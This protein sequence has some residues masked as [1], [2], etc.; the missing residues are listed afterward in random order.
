MQLLALI[1]TL[2][3]IAAKHG[4]LP[5][6]LHVLYNDGNDQ[7]L[8]NLDTAYVDDDH[9]DGSLFVRIVGNQDDDD[10]AEPDERGQDFAAR[11]AVE[12]EPEPDTET[13]MSYSAHDAEFPAAVT[14][15]TPNAEA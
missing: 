12:G 14:R 7:S 3:E 1:D 10:S 6:L 5:V 8:G 13:M 11:A 15:V 9:S 2:Q 4:D